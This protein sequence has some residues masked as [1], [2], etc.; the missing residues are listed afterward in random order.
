MV[1]LNDDGGDSDACQGEEKGLGDDL[2]SRISKTWILISH[3]HW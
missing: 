2:S 3:N 1:M